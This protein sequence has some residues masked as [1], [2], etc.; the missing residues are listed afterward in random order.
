MKKII[1]ILLL[2]F[3]VS[4]F[5]SACSGLN[6]NNSTNNQF[7][8]E[9]IFNPNQ[10]LKIN[11][12]SSDE[13]LSSFLMNHQTQLGTFTSGLETRLMSSSVTMETMDGSA[14]MMNE[15]S[16]TKDFSETNVQVQGIDEADIIK[17]DGDYIY[18]VENHNFFIV[19]VK[20]HENAKIIYSTTY[21]NRP[22]T[23][24][25]NN[26]KLMIMGYV[27]DMDFLRELEYSP[28]RGLSY[29]SIYD[30]SDK[31]NPNLIKDFK[32]DGRI[33]QSR[34]KDNNIYVITNTFNN[35]RHPRPIL[36]DGPNI[37]PIQDIFYFN[38]PYNNPNFVNIYS[39]NID[40]FNHESKSILMDRLETLYMSNNNI[41]LSQTEYINEYELRQKIVKDLI[42]P[43]LTLSDRDR[44]NR[45]NLI[46]N[47]ILSNY[48]KEMKI[49]EII[50]SYVY[51]LNEK[52]QIEYEE[53]LERKLK[54]KLSEYEYFQ[55]SIINKININNGK[56]NVQTTGKIPG[57]ILNQ[58]AMDEYN[59][60]LRVA[61]TVD[62]RWDSFSRDRSKSI[63]HVYTL[64]QQLNIMDKIDNLAEDERIYS[65]RFVGDKLYMVTF[66]EVDPFFVIDLSNPNDI[67]DLGELKIPGFSRYLHPYDENT[68]IGLGQE[69]SETGRILGLKISLFDVSD[70]HNPRE[71]T[72]FIAEGQHS[73]STAE[74]EHK[75]FL[76]SRERNL[77]VIPV[78]SYNWRSPE[79]NYAGA[80]VFNI[81]KDEI[82][83]RGLI[84]HSKGEYSQ[85]VERSLYIDNVL[86]TKSFGL[87]RSN[88]LTDLSSIRNI[89]LERSGPYNVY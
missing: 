65:T 76:F 60:V 46:D 81:T 83:L 7:E 23:I 34:M 66:R 88:S 38:V 82:K 61:T 1:L 16:S 18:I 17:T 64:D 24:F 27:N 58:F 33:F 59:N 53:T 21:K 19:E 73:S 62:A 43:K 48:E 22:E 39:I 3:I 2:S 55:Y 47:D 12:F 40:N 89:T 67:K 78:N 36:M 28:S 50:Y 69:A 14:P 41:Y 72:Q 26:D 57:R 87:L 42:M 29:L 10:D 45:I 44:I 20:E 9:I 13:E 31:E 75:A 84:D 51:M 74:F 63:N 8:N 86:Y 71:I 15:M 4:G 77:L 11:K 68:I 70:V 6:Q 49:M 32:F 52:E 30:I 5:L 80:F 79:N 25:I 56:I 54:D 35:F 37:L 85:G